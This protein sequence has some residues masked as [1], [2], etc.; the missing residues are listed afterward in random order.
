MDQVL[1]LITAV[2]EVAVVRDLLAIHD[3]LCADL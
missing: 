2:V 3:L 1:N